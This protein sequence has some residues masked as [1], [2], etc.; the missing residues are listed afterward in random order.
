[1]RERVG[2]FAVI[3]FLGVSLCASAGLALSVDTNAMS[4]WQGTLSFM[5]GSNLRTQLDYAV[6]APG[7]YGGVAVPAN[8]YVYAYQAFQFGTAAVS[9]VSVGLIDTPAVVG[10]ANAQVDSTYGVL[11]GIVPTA[12]FPML[13]ANSFYTGFFTPQLTANTHSVVLL[14][15]SSN[16][17]TTANASVIDSGM[18]SQAFGAP[19]P[20]PEPATLVL[21]GL[22][23]LAVIRK[24]RGV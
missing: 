9:T 22:S 12:G 16:A 15:T 17:P 10:A 20:L 1:M 23:G 21:L 19:T 11:G 14:F 4:G 8:K 18:S 6:Y 5:S 24:R 2:I 3:V 13:T 7:M